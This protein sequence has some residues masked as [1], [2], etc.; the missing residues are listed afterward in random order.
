[1]FHKTCAHELALRREAARKASTDGDRA[2]ALALFDSVSCDD[3]DEPENLAD[4]MQAA[5]AAGDGER[6]ARA[7]S[8]LEAHPKATA[9]LR[10]RAKA[11]TGDLA[12]ERGDWAAAETAYRAAEAL[13]L[14]EPLARLTTVKRLTA[15]ERPVPQELVRFL[16]E[17]GTHDAAADLVSLRGLVDRAP[18]RGLY[19]YL[20]ARQLEARGRDAEA[21]AE[22]ERALALGLPDARFSREATRMAGVCRLREGRLDEARALFGRLVDDAAAP[23]G[24]RLEAADWLRR[25]DFLTTAQA[26]GTPQRPP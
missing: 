22:L 4:V 25:C 17:T 14:D 12:L 26:G 16:V 19:H 13:P 6:A 23:A 7:A 20:Y 10:A 8:A 1:V 24:L 3:P 15:G 9:S 5:R 11:L 21:A 18:E 2:R